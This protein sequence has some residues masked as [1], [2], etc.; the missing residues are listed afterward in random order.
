MSR[1][2]R[3]AAAPR[4][5]ATR[6]SAQYLDPGSMDAR[7]TAELRRYPSSSCALFVAITNPGVEIDVEDIHQQVGQHVEHS[8]QHHSALD[9]WEISSRN[10][11]HNQSPHTGQGKHGFRHHRATKQRT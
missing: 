6:R 2:I 9:D 4:S 7:M 5:S 11:L 8:D 10:A 1:K 3:H